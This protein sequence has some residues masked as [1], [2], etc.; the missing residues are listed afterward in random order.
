AAGAYKRT[1]DPHLAPSDR[2]RLRLK[3]CLLLMQ[4]YG[5]FAAEKFEKD[6]ARLFPDQDSLKDDYRTAH[7]AAQR[8]KKEAEEHWSQA[9]TLFRKVP[10]SFSEFRVT[11]KFD[12]ALM[13]E[14]IPRRFLRDWKKRAPMFGVPVTI[15]GTAIYSLP[16]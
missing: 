11:E 1:L 10:K 3:A 14:V 2:H 6:F 7:K 8:K 15:Y 16:S 5:E 12:E 9:P 13:A 4:H